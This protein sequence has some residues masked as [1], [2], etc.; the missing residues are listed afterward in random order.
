MQAYCVVYVI[1]KKLNYPSTYSEQS[2][3][4][5][6]IKGTLA[7]DFPS[8]VFIIRRTHTVTH[9]K[10][11]IYIYIYMYRDIYIYIYGFN[12]VDSDFLQWGL[13][14][15]HRTRH[16]TFFPV[17]L[18][19]HWRSICQTGFVL[20]IQ[21]ATALNNRPLCKISRW[22]TKAS[23]ILLRDHQTAKGGN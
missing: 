9:Q 1:W 15:W 18:K 2:M 17:P 5:I 21:C 11:D 12:N 19:G 4:I 13:A 20:L 6:K 22:C 16:F 3:N 23:N 14:P 10:P 8:S 7:Q